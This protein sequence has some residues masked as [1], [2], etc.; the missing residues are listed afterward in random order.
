[1]R[2]WRLAIGLALF[3]MVGAWSEARA[4]DTKSAVSPNRLKLPKG[5]G[6]LEGVGENVEPNLSMGL[7][8]Y[9]VPIELPAGHNGHSPSLR[10]AYSS[11]SGNSSVGIGWSLAVPSI[12][13]MTVRGV[14]RYTTDDLMAAG[15]SDELVPVERGADRIVYRARF[16]GGFVRYT[17]FH[18]GAGGY[19]LAEYPDGKRAYF[20]DPRRYRGAKRHRRRSCRHLPLAARRADRHARPPHRLRVRAQPVRGQPPADDPM[21]RTSRRHLPLRRPARL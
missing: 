1:M 13:R 8:S 6:S 2:P 5:P 20:G 21:G 17:W 15:G 10:L 3:V 12:E 11:G 16:E 18:P 4:D 7:M 14:P 9:G 19:W